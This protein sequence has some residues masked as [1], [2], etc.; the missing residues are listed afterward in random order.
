MTAPNLHPIFADILKPWSPPPPASQ[1]E[2]PQIAELADLLAKSP[3]PTAQE[4]R[5]AMELAYK[6]GRVDGS[7]ASCEKMLNPS[8]AA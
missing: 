7:L 4:I 5:H 3:A 6:M 2:N 1:I 8:S